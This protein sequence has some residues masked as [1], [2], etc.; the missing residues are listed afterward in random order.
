MD[1]KK[2]L[3]KLAISLLLSPI[4]V[5]LVLLAA[6]AAGSV[7]EMSHGETFIIWLLMAIVIN[8]SLTGKE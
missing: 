6:K 4:V 2:S 1:Y 8:L 7:Y 5:Y 3:L